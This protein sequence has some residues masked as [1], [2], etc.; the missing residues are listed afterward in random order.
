VHLSPRAVEIDG[1]DNAT[2]QLIRVRSVEQ[3]GM[4]RGQTYRL[5]V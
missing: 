3:A 4:Y 5:P 1:R 2:A